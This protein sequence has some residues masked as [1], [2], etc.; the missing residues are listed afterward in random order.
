LLGKRLN[1]LN[2]LKVLRATEIGAAL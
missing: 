1:I 2:L